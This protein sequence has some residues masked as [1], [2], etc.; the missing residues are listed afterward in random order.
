MK[1]SIPLVGIAWHPVAGWAG[2]I[3]ETFH[4]AGVPPLT[5]HLGQAPGPWLAK[6]FSAT[7]ICSARD[8]EAGDP[9]PPLELQVAGLNCSPP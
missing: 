4:T 2:L 5:P 7:R 6:T 9:T 8:A 1:P 3:D